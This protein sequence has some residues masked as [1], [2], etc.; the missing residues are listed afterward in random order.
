MVFTRTLQIFPNYHWPT[1][2]SSLNFTIITF[3]QPWGKQQLTSPC[4]VS[5]EAVHFRWL[6]TSNR[7][8]WN[9]IVNCT[10]NPV[11]NWWKRK[12]SW[13]RCV[14]YRKSLR[15]SKRSRWS[16]FKGELHMRI[17][18]RGGCV[19]TQ[20]FCS[21]L[22]AL[23]LMLFITDAICLN[24]CFVVE[25]TLSHS[26]KSYFHASIFNWPPFQIQNMV[27]HVIAP[28]QICV[29]SFLYPM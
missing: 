13:K 22:A 28:L 16:L 25:F 14:Y 10:G 8:N 26:S 17:L 12:T 11:F 24:T 27:Q 21:M 1:Y 23:H 18:L 4:K 6:L 20:V 9:E 19:C 5:P 3:F 7:E 2:K 15:N 29:W